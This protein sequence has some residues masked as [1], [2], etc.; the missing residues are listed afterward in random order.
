[1]IATRV[2]PGAISLSSS[3]NFA[4]RLNSYAIKPVALPP[5]RARLATRPLPTGSIVVT[6]TIGTV[7]LACCKSPTIELAVPTMTSGANATNS[8][9]YRRKR[10][11]SPAP[12]R[13]STCTLA[14]TSQPNCCNP[15]ANAAIQVCPNEFVGGRGH[16][17]ANAAHAM[18]LLRAYRERPRHCR[19]TKRGNEFSPF[20]V[21]PHRTLQRGS[22]AP[23]TDDSTPQHRGL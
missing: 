14:P 3:N 6:N 23:D 9:A 4:L 20:D 7:R 1:M 11:V 21:D 10:S 19:A 13:V 12:Q 22:R 16:Q 5:G 2:T 8:A 18:G 15:C 17:Y